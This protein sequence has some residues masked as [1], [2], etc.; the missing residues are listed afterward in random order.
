MDGVVPSCGI[1]AFDPVAVYHRSM[2]KC[3]IWCTPTPPSSPR[4]TTVNIPVFT[5]ALQGHP[6]DLSTCCRADLK[7]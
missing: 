6:I 4:S 2:M 7:L 5:L 1:D 3:I